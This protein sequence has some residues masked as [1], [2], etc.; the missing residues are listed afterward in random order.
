MAEHALYIITPCR[1][2]FIDLW[3]QFRG[4]D[5]A[6]DAIAHRT[7]EGLP[8]DVVSREYARLLLSDADA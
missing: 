2:L 8:V 1:I 3:N 7:I 5:M 4:R 6:W